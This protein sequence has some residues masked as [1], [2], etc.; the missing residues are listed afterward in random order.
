MQGNHWAQRTAQALVSAHPHLD[1]FVLAA[2]LSPSGPVS[3]SS[4][5]EVVITYFVSRAL[6]A[7]GKRT[8][9]IFSWDDFDRL[10]AVP[11]GLDSAYQKYVGMPYSAIPDPHGCCASYA[12]HY[13]R[14][15]ETTLADMGIDVEF[16]YQT[17]QYQSGRY[18][19]GIHRALLGRR[20]IYDIL[21]SFKGPGS[22][23]AIDN[24]TVDKGIVDKTREAFYPIN[25]YCERC[26]KDHTTVDGYDEGARIL[27]YTCSC[28]HWG[29]QSV[30]EATNIKLLWKVDWAMRWM[31]EQVVF[32]PGGRSH[33]GATGSY[34]VSTV[35][36]REI[37]GYTAPAYMPYEVVGLKGTRSPITPRE[38][39]MVY[40][41]EV[42]LSVFMQYPPQ[43]A[44]EI[45]MG[46]EVLKYHQT[47]EASYQQL[48][49]GTLNREDQRFA[50][51]LCVLPQTPLRLAPFSQVAAVLPLVGYDRRLCSEVLGPQLS[52][53]SVGAFQEAC[54]RAR[55]WID[56]W[57][58]ERAPRVNR[59]FNRAYY[60]RLST[61][62]KNQLKAL[63]AS[64]TPESDGL[65]WQEAIRA[66][67][68]GEDTAVTLS[69]G[70]RTIADPN[71]QEQLIAAVYHLLI[72][73]D[74][75]PRLPLLVD[76]VGQGHAYHLLAGTVR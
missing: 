4:F 19:E 35:L 48:C 75:G 42:L 49:E 17:Q 25:L 53:V 7:L 63:V 69:R 70:H 76:V 57:H 1:T 14:D 68:Q 71:L 52:G 13:E 26:G 44:F 51:H 5:R 45:G 60:V 65:A 28:G 16:L 55:H 37:F 34:N 22:V 43:A 56:R 74:K 15:F 27:Y 9:L 58:P 30:R 41:P 67:V 64:L 24:A 32:E 29:A 10:R 50:M 8:R 61:A 33:S 47:F 12:E 23:G 11:E 66:V 21:M 20:Q 6:Q 18:R 38:L 59:A 73:R 39:L 72:S 2:G 40:A 54:D 62:V 46:D 3:L 31:E 36:A